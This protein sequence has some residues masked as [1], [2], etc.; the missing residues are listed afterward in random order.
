MD[1]VVKRFDIVLVNLD[2][3]VGREINKVRPAIVL[4][5]NALNDNWATII[6]APMT[7]T[8]R[9]LG[10]RVNIQ[11]QN[12]EGQACMDQLRSVDKKRIVK[13]LGTLNK[14]YQNK[15]LHT[16]QEMFRD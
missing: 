1:L 4:S 15:V 14:K 7:S 8:L 10:F 9:K 16:C 12:K 5:P 6:I 2:P 3:T 11:F 13:T